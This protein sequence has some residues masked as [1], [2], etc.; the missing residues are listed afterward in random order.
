LEESVA[1]SN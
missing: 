1:P